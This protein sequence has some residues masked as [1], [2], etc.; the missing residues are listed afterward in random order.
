MKMP[1]M[2]GDYRSYS[3]SVANACE[4]GND[5]TLVSVRVREGK[6]HGMELLFFFV[7]VSKS[8]G[9]ENKKEPLVH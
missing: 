5:C 3:E 1:R 9:F 8:R 6:C 2:A 4:G 7:R